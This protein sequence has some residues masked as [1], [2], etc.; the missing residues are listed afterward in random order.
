M[1]KLA[2]KGILAC[3]SLGEGGFVVGKVRKLI[4]VV[5]PKQIIRNY[6]EVLTH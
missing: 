5:Q 4:P 1:W 6:W 3:R 2:G